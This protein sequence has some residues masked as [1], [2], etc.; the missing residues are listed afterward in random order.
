M[1]LSRRVTTGLSAQR[2][3]LWGQGWVASHS[4]PPSGRGAPWGSV[5]ARSFRK[6]AQHGKGLWGGLGEPG[7]AC[8]LLALDLSSLPQ[9]KRGL[10]EALVVLQMAVCGPLAAG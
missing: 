6:D 7:A 9:G 2:A 8:T 1:V 5:F 4:L 3:C 10:A